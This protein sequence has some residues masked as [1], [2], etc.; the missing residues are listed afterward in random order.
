MTGA[1]E[2]ERRYRRLLRWYPRPF[3]AERGEEM[4]AVLMASGCPSRNSATR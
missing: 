1:A 4:L 2:V 3:R